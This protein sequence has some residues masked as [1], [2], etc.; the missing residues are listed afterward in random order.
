ME[1]TSQ[2]PIN[3]RSSLFYLVYYIRHSVSAILGFSIVGI[4]LF[5]ALF[6][7]LIA[8]FEAETAYPDEA[9]EP[10]SA[11]HLFGTDTIGMDVFSRVIAAPRLD[12]AIAV[13]AQALAFL[14]GAPLGIIAGYYKGWHIEILMRAF[15]FLQ[16]FPVFILALALVTVTGQNLS[17]VI[18]VIGLINIPVYARLVRGEVLALK[19]RDFVEAARIADNTD[20]SIMFR[21]I[22]P[23]SLTSALIQTSA[24][25]GATILLTAGLSFIGVGVRMPQAEWGLMISRGARNMI[26]GH[27]WPAFFPGVAMAIAV[28]GFALVGDTLRDALDPTKRR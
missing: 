1:T 16:A 8:P 7:P 2:S 18:I 6:G 13:S 5:L 28:L 19:T 14:I 20:L 22:M 26:T 12:F 9:L 17:N 11:R 3:Q 27:W 10:P 23:N 24:N 4:L 21:H 15:D 25:I